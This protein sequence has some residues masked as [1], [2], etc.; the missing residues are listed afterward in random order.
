ML[1]RLAGPGKDGRSSGSVA[2][3]CVLNC[4][5]EALKTFST[6][7]SQMLST[8]PIVMGKKRV[9]WKGD[10]AVKTLCSDMGVLGSV[11]SPAG[12]S[13]CLP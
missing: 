5:R 4:S 13:L 9:E 7:A 11:P 12:D 1:G 2:F 10:P 6:R 3:L 8:V